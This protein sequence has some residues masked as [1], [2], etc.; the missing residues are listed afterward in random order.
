[1]SLRESGSRPGAKAATVV[2]VF[3]FVISGGVGNRLHR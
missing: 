2:L 1:M 3:T